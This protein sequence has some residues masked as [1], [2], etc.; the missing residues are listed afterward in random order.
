M[1]YK[2]EVYIIVYEGKNKTTIS[3]FT[4]FWPTLY[5]LTNTHYLSSLCISKQ[6]H[7]LMTTLQSLIKSNKLL[8]N[9]VLKVFNEKL[10]LWL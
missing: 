6:R 3:L 5:L 8:R 7:D 2:Y 9:Y 1:W 10:Y 4:Y